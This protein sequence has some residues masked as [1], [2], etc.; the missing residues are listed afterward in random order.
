MGQKGPKRARVKISKQALQIVV[1]SHPT[2]GGFFILKK[3][4]NVLIS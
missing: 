4:H 3:P 2:Q 1:G